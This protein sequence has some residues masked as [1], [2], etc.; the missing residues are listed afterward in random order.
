MR[1]TLGSTTDQVILLT[2]SKVG[3]SRRS[4]WKK[5]TNRT[6]EVIMPLLSQRV[7][8]V[9]VPGWWPDSILVAFTYMQ[10]AMNVTVSPTL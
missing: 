6:M 7:R 2:E 1:Y 10:P 4:M 3:S 5:E 9:H 8:S